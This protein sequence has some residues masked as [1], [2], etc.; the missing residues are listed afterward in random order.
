MAM[1]AENQL[2]AYCLGHHEGLTPMAFA[3]LGHYTTTEAG[4]VNYLHIYT[5]ALRVGSA[6]EVG[7]AKP[8]PVNT[9]SGLS[10]SSR[11]RAV[12]TGTRSW[13]CGTCLSNYPREGPNATLCCR[14]HLKTLEC[15]NTRGFVTKSGNFFGRWAYHLFESVNGETFARHEP[16]EASDLAVAALYRRALALD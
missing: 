2:S 14:Q 10:G 15:R 5:N 12:G 1:A 13:L 16:I 4:C 3:R 7:A 6:L 11:D 9:S 8:L